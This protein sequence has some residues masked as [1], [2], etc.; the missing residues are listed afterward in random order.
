M[1]MMMMGL[2]QIMRFGHPTSLNH[3]LIGFA[4]QETSRSSIVCQRNEPSPEMC[5]DLIWE[6]KVPTSL[7][8]EKKNLHVPPKLMPRGGKKK[9]RSKKGDD[10]SWA[11]KKQKVRE[12]ANEAL[13]DGAAPVANIPTPVGGTTTPGSAVPSSPASQSSTQVAAS[14][15]PVPQPPTTMA[16]AP[17]QAVTALVA[18]GVSQQVMKTAQLQVSLFADLFSA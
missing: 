4:A 2:C 9:K 1:M 18:A 3:Q 17:A 16:A 15:T 6:R 11:A 5:Q 7:L 12:G 14:A 10:V 13:Q 8:G